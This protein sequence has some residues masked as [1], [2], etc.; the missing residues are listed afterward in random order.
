MAMHTKQGIYRL[1]RFCILP[2]IDW[3]DFEIMHIETD[4]GH[5]CEN[6]AVLVYKFNIFNKN[7]SKRRG[8]NSETNAML[9]RAVAT[10]PFDVGMEQGSALHPLRKKATIHHITTMLGTSKNVLFPGHNYLITT[11]TDDPTLE[12]SPS[13][14]LER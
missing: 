14:A 9:F 3:S 2:V 7:S 12:L 11:G 1:V 5:L 13:L 10:T 8:G 6:K 4:S